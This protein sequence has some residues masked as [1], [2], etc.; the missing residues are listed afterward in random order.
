M[1]RQSNYSLDMRKSLLALLVVM[2]ALPARAQEA[3]HVLS[4]IH[5]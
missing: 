5:I 4:L 2:A 1:V 3:V